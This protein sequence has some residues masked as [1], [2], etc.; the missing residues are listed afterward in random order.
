[1]LIITLILVAIPKSDYSNIRPF[2]TTPI[3]KL[4]KGINVSIFSYAGFEILLVIF[5][6]LRTTKNAF[7]ATSI[8]FIII[9]MDYIIAFIECIAKF[10][11]KETESFIYPVISLIRASQVPGGIIER[12]EGLLLA[13]WVTSVFTLALWD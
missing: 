8:A 3:I 4:I 10:G 2:F 5:P 7:K 9:I 12:L 11:V 13:F 1:M 6:F